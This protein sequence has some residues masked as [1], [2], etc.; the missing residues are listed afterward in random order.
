MFCLIDPPT[1]SQYFV[2]RRWEISLAP[3]SPPEWH[4]PTNAK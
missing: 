1:K 4:A 2:E 3:L